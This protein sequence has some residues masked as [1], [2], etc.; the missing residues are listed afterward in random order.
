MTSKLEVESLRLPILQLRVRR[1]ISA[2][3]LLRDRAQILLAPS[4]P[5]A[6]GLEGR[7]RRRCHALA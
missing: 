3:V 6:G 2:A 5:T 4:L 1:Q 7:S